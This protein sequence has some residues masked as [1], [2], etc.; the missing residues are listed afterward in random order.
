MS[1]PV[2]SGAGEPFG[3]QIGRTYREST[4]WWPEVA[5]APE[6][7]PNV[8]YIVLDDVG[9]AHLGCYGSDIATPHMDRLAAGGLRYSNF[10]TTAMCSPTRAS[11]LSGRNHH[12]A[13]VGTV[14]EFAVGYP[15]YQNYL[16]KRAATLAEML[17]PRGYST[18][19]VGKWHLLPLR[20]VT[21]AGPFD[22]WPTRRGFDRWYGFPGG[23]TDSWHPEL[24]DGTTAVEVRGGDGYHL[25]DDLID[26]A[27]EYV[28]DQQSAAPERPF[29]LYVALGACHWPH[30]APASY[31]EKYRGRYDR[32][33]DV[34]RQEW[35]ARQ[36]A[37][38]IVPADVELPPSDPDVPAWESLSPDERRL[39]ARHME[40]YA[41]FLEHTDA[42]IGRLVAYLAEIGQLDNTLLML[43][44]DNGASGEGGRLGCVNV[45]LQY[46]SGQR[47]TVE[48]GLAALDRLGDETT[49][50]HYPVGWAQAGCTPLKW[51][52]MNTH[53]G[54]V[55]DPLIVHWPARI[56]D[57]GSLRHQY[58]HVVDLTPTVLDVL[59]IEAPSVVNG[60]P[61]MPM[62]GTSLAYTFEQPEAPTRKQTQYYEMLGDRGLWHQGWKAVVRHAAGSDWDD[63]RWELY[64]LDEDYAELHDLAEQEPARLRALVERWWAEAGANNVLPLDDRGSPR[65]LTGGRPN[66]RTT[67]T[68]L[69]G[70]ARIERWNTPNVTNRS[71]TV[72]ADVEIPTGGAEG[73][74]LAAGNRFGGYV[75]FVQDG[76]LQFEYNAGHTRYH[77]ASESTLQPGAHALG[78]DVAKTG[79]LRAR[80]TLLVDGVPVGS[81]ALARTWPINPARASLFCGRDGGSPVSDAY[82]CPYPFTGVLHRTVVRLGDDQRRDPE[83]ER[84]AALAED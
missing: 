54:G 78:L 77:V 51:Y 84:R 75:L 27:I 72:A 9:F 70:M 45:D 34:A 82:A 55:R 52:K 63:D 68:F 22:Y 32:G 19:A 73:V 21:A 24:Y 83:A 36:K 38:G 31:I 46:Q 35:L 13:G 58:H 66:P 59:G 64:H 48:D 61:Q 44:S 53:G 12:A 57:G 26:H 5:R 40:V 81:V 14:A 56:G 76:R 42:Q 41:G 10:H 65:T 79:E 29:F 62:Q 15:G 16:S 7:A 28:R 60:V 71:F 30:Q 80:A 3:G 50:P 6:G 67:Y 49:N 4:P 20:D 69:P 39:A 8:V 23:Y 2:M 43:I 1:G 47:E 25:T 33:W 17:G 18:L 11:L 74:L 37:L